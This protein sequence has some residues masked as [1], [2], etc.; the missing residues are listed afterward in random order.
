VLSPGAY[1]FI[2][3]AD[4]GIKHHSDML[5]PHSALVREAGQAAI[6]AGVFFAFDNGEYEIKDTFS[7]TLD[8]WEFTPEHRQA[9][10]DFMRGAYL[11]REKQ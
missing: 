4:G 1:K 11:M 7:S 3:T 6:A 5:R 2:V 9:L 8:L 10:A